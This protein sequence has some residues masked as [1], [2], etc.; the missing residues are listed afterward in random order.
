M[1]Y[2]S[3]G[4]VLSMPPIINGDRSKLTSKTKNVFIE[5]T[6]IDLT[7]AKVVLDTLVTI[8]SQYCRRPFVVEPVEV[9]QADGSVIV[10]PVRF[11]CFFS[12]F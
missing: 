8:F 4:E 1:I 9:V 12:I 6:A 11:L 10:Y 7:K 5:C 2:D 3:D